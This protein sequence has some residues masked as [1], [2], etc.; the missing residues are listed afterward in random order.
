MS[1]GVLDHLQNRFRA[2]D[3][4]KVVAPVVAVAKR[5]AALA[6]V[7]LGAKAH[8]NCVVSPELA[9]LC[10][11]ADHGVRVLPLVIDR[12]REHRIAVF[13]GHPPGTLFGCARCKAGDH[14]VAVG[15]RFGHVVVFGM[16]TDD[17]RR[18]HAGPQ[19]V[20]IILEQHRRP[21]KR[22]AGKNGETPHDSHQ[23]NT[24][25]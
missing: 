19:G 10:H 23:E 22:R 13:L 17:A 9:A 11:R 15:R 8:R 7:R 18:E 3:A 5:H 25:G 14:P 4:E 6:L 2:F 24:P 12:L 20:E 16:S 21:A 1:D